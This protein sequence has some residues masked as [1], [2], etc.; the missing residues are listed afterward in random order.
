MS[1][2]TAALKKDIMRL[3]RSRLLAD[4]S[5]APHLK[6]IVDVDTDP[7][8]NWLRVWDLALDYGPHGMS[9]ALAMLK[10]LGLQSFSGNC[11]FSSCEHYLDNENLGSHFLSIHTKVSVTLS[12]C[13]LALKNLSEEIFTHEQALYELFLCRD[14]V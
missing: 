7:E 2:S 1:F 4:A 5:T 8:C 3:D 12:D 13:E 10:L 14:Y 6:H 9:Y 11:P